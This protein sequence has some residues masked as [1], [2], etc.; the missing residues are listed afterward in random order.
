MHLRARYP[1]RS[2]QTVTIPARG[3]TRPRT[4]RILKYRLKVLSE[5]YPG[6]LTALPKLDRPIHEVAAQYQA[7]TIEVMRLSNL[8]GDLALRIGSSRETAV[9]FVRGSRE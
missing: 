3:L 9:Q 1:W 2:L 7:S 8:L 5:K 6:I 4:I